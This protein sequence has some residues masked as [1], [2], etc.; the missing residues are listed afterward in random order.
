MKEDVIERILKGAYEDPDGGGRIGV[1]TKTVAIAGSLDGWEVDLVAG[2]GMGGRLAVVS[3]ANTE[4]ALGARVK[5]AL[6]SVVEIIPVLLPGRPH[7]D[8]ETVG[9][10][11][12]ATVSA[13]AL[14]AVGSGTINDL[15]KYTA[16]RSGKPYA[17]FGTA[18]S[19][20][21]YT[22]VNAA[23]TEKG[24]KKTLPAVAA[25]GVFLDLGVLSKSP[26]RMI[27]S[28]LGDSI[29][30][31]T[32][33]AD[34]LLSQLL[35]GGEYRRAPFDILA[36][37]EE[38]LMSAPEALLKGDAGAMSHLARTLVL[39]GFGMTICNGSYP[40]SQGEHLISHYIDMLGSKGWP[41]SFHGE[42]IGV[43]TLTMAEIQ[44]KVLSEKM[45]RVSPSRMTADSFVSHYG[46][47][48]GSECMREFLK[49][50][51][52]DA[53]AEKLNDRLGREWDGIREK[54]AGVTR[55]SGFLRGVLLRAG[56]PAEPEQIGWPRDFYGE[57]VRHAREIRDRYT[58]LDFAAD[59]GLMD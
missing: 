13:D 51:L 10:I 45:P 32:A 44:E 31:P 55:P 25:S 40:A 52:D 20:N 41:E 24:M 14:I 50:R 53:G 49:K 9:M 39:S 23:I 43:T 22:S 5:R 37:D 18:P 35:F 42:Q 46:A 56:A 58:F 3:D 36:Q 57:A 38:A 33:Q 28:G 8:M 11:S 6:S 21:G 26:S 47:E 4:A 29:C 15:C 2:L 19:M 12:K 16:A 7:A 48:L 17:V 27:L 34:W 54:V 30:R 59:C 1:P